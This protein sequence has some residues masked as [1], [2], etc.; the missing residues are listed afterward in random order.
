VLKITIPATRKGIMLTAHNTPPI[1]SH[2]ELPSDAI[3]G[4]GGLEPIALRQHDTAIEKII[5]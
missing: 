3:I 2:K 1:P 4:S 5:M